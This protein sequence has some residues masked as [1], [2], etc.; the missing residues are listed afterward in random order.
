[1][2]GAVGSNGGDGNKAIKITQEA[3]LESTVK[4]VGYSHIKW[5]MTQTVTAGD[6]STTITVTVSEGIT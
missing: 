6:Y 1:M 2:L 5:G 3:G 4:L